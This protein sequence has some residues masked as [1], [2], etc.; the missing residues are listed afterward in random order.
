M[1]NGFKEFVLRGNAV[2]LAVG[3]VIGAAF[4]GVVTAL[5]ESFL[6]PLI[7]AIFGKPDFTQLWA[8]T[9]RGAHTG[10]TGER[11]DPSVIQVGAILTALVNLLLVAIALYFFVVLPVNRLS[12]LRK[13]GAEPEPEAPAED[14]LLL[15]EIRDLLAA[16]G[17]RTTPSRSSAGPEV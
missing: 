4:T 15:Q 7:A 2:D 3:V 6:T 8:I 5:V 12:Q 13:A 11:V 9:I 10:L 14:V 17:G 1:L 16:N